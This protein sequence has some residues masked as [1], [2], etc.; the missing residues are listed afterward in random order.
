KA[1]PAPRARGL[2]LNRL[3]DTGELARLE[4]AAAAAFGVGDPRRVVATGGTEPALRLLPYVLGQKRAIVAGPTYGSHAEGWQSAGLSTSVVPDSQLEGSVADLTAVIVVN[5]N[6]PDGR[7]VSRE[8]LLQLHG[9]VAARGGVL[10][11]DEAFA[12]VVPEAS[13]A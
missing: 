8:R 10:I 3:P 6:N 9:A 5:P 7:V 4:A 1:Y 11:V 12:E 13:V 2:A